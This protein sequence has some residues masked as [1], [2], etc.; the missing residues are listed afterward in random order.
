MAENS[1]G[2]RKS[3]FTHI[4]EIHAERKNEKIFGGATKLSLFRSIL[5][6]FKNEADKAGKI[7]RSEKLA[8]RI[9]KIDTVKNNVLVKYICKELFMFFLVFFF[10][11]FAIFF[12]NQLLL[13]IQTLL[14]KHVPFWTS[15][16]L[17]FYYMPQIVSQSA[18]FATLVGF[19]VCLG[20]MV[21]DNEILIFRASGLRYMKIFLPVIFMGIIISLFSFLMNDYFLPLGNQKS[22]KL[23]KEIVAS[24]PAVQLE[25]HSVTSMDSTSIVVGDVNKTEISDIIIFDQSSSNNPKIII[26]G[27]S[28]VKTGEEPGV[29][30]ELIMND[31]DVF[32][33][34]VI[35]RNNFDVL[36]SQQASL[37]IFE[38]QIDGFSS[39]LSPREMTSRDLWKKIKDLK[40]KKEEVRSSYM[41]EFNR[42]FS[43]PFGSI[44]FAF[45]AFPL[46]LIF[47]KK[48]G[49]TLGLIFGVVLSVAYWA[50]TLV[51]Q[52]IALRNEGTAF[53]CTWVPNFFLGALGLFLYMRLRKK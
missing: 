22:Q 5:V 33:L 17:I 30:M 25:A 19:L 27:P 34:D 26:S 40:A 7:R 23:M 44:F 50:A 16:R 10:I 35:R 24:N 8:R 28:Q 29:L 53:L 32:M 2:K 13:V 51:G 36:K 37:S 6:H 20:R 43:V 14:K 39:T 31:A 45:L 48:D 38:D 47:G 3:I 4:K 21:T 18:P 15:L 12:V 46:A 11:F 9:E 1:K 42:K 52:M 49:Q 41:I